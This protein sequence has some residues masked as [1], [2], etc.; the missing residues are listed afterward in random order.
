MDELIEPNFYSVLKEWGISTD[1]YPNGDY[2][3]E[4]AQIAWDAYRCGQRNTHCQEVHPQDW[5][6]PQPGGEQS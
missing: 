2:K 4:T 5:P 3:N 6:P 1:R